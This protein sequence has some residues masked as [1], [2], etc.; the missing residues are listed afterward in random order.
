MLVHVRDWVKATTAL[1]F[2]P[3]VNLCVA[4]VL[5]SEHATHQNNRGCSATVSGNGAE[6]PDDLPDK[7]EPFWTNRLQSVKDRAQSGPDQ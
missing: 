2:I 6:R 7:S 3:P 5:L 1:G 4:T